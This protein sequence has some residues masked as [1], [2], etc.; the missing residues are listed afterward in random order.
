MGDIFYAQYT[1]DFQS[2]NATAWGKAICFLSCPK[3]SNGSLADITSQFDLMFQNSIQASGD[4]NNI[5]LLY[6]GY[7]FSHTAVWAS[8]DR[9][10]SPEIWDRAL[11][12]YAMALVDVLDIIPASQLGHATILNILRTIAPRI[13]NAADP[14]SGVWWLVMTKPG[15]AGNYF[16]SS[17]S[18]MFVY[19]LLKG[20]RLGYIP[21]P[22]GSIVKAAAK[23]YQYMTSHW[24]VSN[25]DGTMSW[26]NTV[27][28]HL[29]L[30]FPLLSLYVKLLC[31]RS[32]V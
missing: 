28:V 20:V 13:R 23:A 8:P 12:W 31:Y 10:H 19:A 15:R 17:G 16:E 3:G 14:S 24:V 18:A 1:K 6:H 32:E 22:D 29:L 30:L 5:G 4:A 21:D 2:S 7:D 26:T 11:G 25:S 27:E 9:G